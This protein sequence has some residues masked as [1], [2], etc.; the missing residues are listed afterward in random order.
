MDI[1]TFP[2]RVMELW[3]P[4]L[5]AAHAAHAATR[6]MCLA[7]ERRKP[8]LGAA[9]CRASDEVILVCL[10]VSEVTDRGVPRW[11]RLFAAH[12]HATNELFKVLSF[13]AQME[14][15]TCDS[16]NST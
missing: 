1:S 16:T 3:A 15:P 8:D 10:R 14:K 9:A 12:N 2:D 11:A 4:A 7:G 5:V 6:W 13:A